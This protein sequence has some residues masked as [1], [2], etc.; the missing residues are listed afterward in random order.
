MT[1]D[2][3]TIRLTQLAQAKSLV[4]GDPSYFP[5]I[6]IGVLPVFV[7]QEVRLRRWVA[8]FVLLAFSSPLLPQTEKCDLGLKIV[9][10]LSSSIVTE[11]D[12]VV[13]KCFV[14]VC[15]ILYPLLFQHM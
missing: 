10:Q 3:V 9:E 13:R 1:E 14:Q 8:D 11:E 2:S 4:D 15:T 7:D 6:V 12:L 5:Q